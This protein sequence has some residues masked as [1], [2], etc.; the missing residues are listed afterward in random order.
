MKEDADLPPL[1]NPD[2]LIGKNDLTSLMYLHE[3]A[4]LYNLRV[5]FANHGAIYTYCGQWLPRG[6]GICSVCADVLRMYVLRSVY[7]RNE[8]VR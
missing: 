3:P 1:R 2:L 6:P 5:R 4:V 8:Y 7:H